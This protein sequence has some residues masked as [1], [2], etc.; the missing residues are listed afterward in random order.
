MNF[1]EAVRRSP[2]ELGMP[3]SSPGSCVVGQKHHPLLFAAVRRRSA[4]LLT[5]NVISAV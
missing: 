1:E 5:N 2:V 4:D 3:K